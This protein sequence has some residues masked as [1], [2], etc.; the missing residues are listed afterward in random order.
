M[1]TKKVKFEMSLWQRIRLASM[2]W[3]DIVVTGELECVDDE[4]EDENAHTQS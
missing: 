2:M 4:D 3:W 1:K